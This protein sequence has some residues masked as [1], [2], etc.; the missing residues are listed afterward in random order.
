MAGASNVCSICGSSYDSDALFCPK[1]GGPLGSSALAHPD[2]YIGAQ[3]GPS[4]RI[5][6]LIGVGS[7]G[8]VYRAAQA[9]A[10]RAVAVKILHKELST[11]ASIVARFEREAQ[12]AARLSHPNVIEVFAAGQAPAHGDESG[13]LYLTMEYL[14][15]ISLRSALAGAGGALPVRRALR[16]ALQL[17]EG[18]GEAHAQGIVH[19]DLKPEN[20]MLLRRGVDADFVKVLDF[21]MARL[22]FGSAPA[23]TRAGLVFGT[24]R[25]ISPEGAAGTPVGPAADVYSIAI[26]VYQ[27]LAGRTPFEGT[28]SVEVLTKQIHDP[29]PPLSAVERAR[30]VPAAVASVIMANLAK[31]PHQRLADARALGRALAGAMRAS[32]AAVDELRTPSTPI[33]SDPPSPPSRGAA[34]RPMQYQAE[35]AAPAFAA[36]SS[37]PSALPARRALVVAFLAGCMLLGALLAVIGALAWRDPPSSGA[38]TGVH[39]TSEDASVDR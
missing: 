6:K 32:G 7:M 35:L 13:P 3:I 9:P 23:V 2:A 12:I 17:C 33:A 11:D 15:G 8:R 27:M 10:G 20:V 28:S 19:R 14:D 18:V 16:I 22:P 24:A 25:Y 36:S 30:A 1:D 34:T 26:I 31:K 21:G 5:E 38:L 4:I 39:R 29:P 37:R